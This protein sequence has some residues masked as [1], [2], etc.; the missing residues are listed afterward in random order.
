MAEEGLDCKELDTV[1]L[2]SPK[3]NIEQAVGRIL[4]KEASKRDKIPQIVDIIDCFS[5]F[6]KQ[7]IK[8][9]K[10]YKK[11]K[12]NIEEIDLTPFEDSNDQGNES[13]S[14]LDFLE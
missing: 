10:F 7:G 8:R 2:V 5:S 14:E 3:S 13:N 4:R 6:E 9:L 1:Y 12:Y 11:N